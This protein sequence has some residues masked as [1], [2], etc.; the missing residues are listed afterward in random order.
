MNLKWLE[1]YDKLVE[2]KIS[3]KLQLFL[4]LANLPSRWLSNALK[5]V[6]KH[7]FLNVTTGIK[8]SA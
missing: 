2:E 1:Y 5:K 4:V 8:P 3:L 6:T 7:I